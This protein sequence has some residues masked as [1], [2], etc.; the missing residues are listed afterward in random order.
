MK[1]IARWGLGVFIFAFCVVISATIAVILHGDAEGAPNFWI[2]L[3]GAIVG[4]SAGSAAFMTEDSFFEDSNPTIY[5]NK[6]KKKIQTAELLVKSNKQSFFFLYVAVL[7]MIAVLFG[8]SIGEVEFNSNMVDVAKGWA[9]LLGII[10]PGLIMLVASVVAPPF[11]IFLLV[12]FI[13]GLVNEIGRIDSLAF[14][15]TF[16]DTFIYYIE[17]LPFIVIALRLFTAIRYFATHSKIFQFSFYK[18]LPLM[19]FTLI[20]LSMVGMKTY[21]LMQNDLVFKDFLIVETIGFIFIAILHIVFSI[22]DEAE[23]DLSTL[24]K[25]FK[26]NQINLFLILPVV[27]LGTLYYVV[28]T[29]SFS[30]EVSSHIYYTATFFTYTSLFIIMWRSFYNSWK[31]TTY[32]DNGLLNFISQTINLYIIAIGL[33]MTVLAFVYNTPTVT[34][35]FIVALLLLTALSLIYTK[36]LGLINFNSSTHPN[37]TSLIKD[38]FILISSN[39]PLVGLLFL[40]IILPIFLPLAEETFKSASSIYLPIIG[41]ALIVGGDYVQNKGWQPLDLFMEIIGFLIFISTFIHLFF[42][43]LMVIPLVVFGI[44]IS[45]LISNKVFNFFGRLTNISKVLLVVIVSLSGILAASKIY[46]KETVYIS[47]ATL[48]SG[49]TKLL[50]SDKMKKIVENDKKAKE[51]LKY[52]LAVVVQ[53][54]KEKKK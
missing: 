39:I 32:G 25:L 28:N 5:E 31:V 18:F 4:L 27:I 16:S 51:Y 40:F 38:I 36:S 50:Y 20:I 2:M 1:T 7:Y 42:Y 33:S 44:F 47:N 48:L 6:D 30:F 34:I 26:I 3:G 12:V 46:K 9:G 14:S 21:Y 37:D 35:I 49:E 29:I 15:L 43:L 11:F 8:L 17:P 52:N 10:I 45:A 24:N 53:E 23:D 54:N 19:I 41:I 13:F 22:F